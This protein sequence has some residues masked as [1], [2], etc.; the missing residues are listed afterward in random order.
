MKNLQNN[1]EQERNRAVMEIRK[2]CEHEKQRAIENTRRETK[3]TTWC[4]NCT[5]E[6][7]FYCCWNTSYCGQQCQKTHWQNHQKYCTNV[8]STERGCSISSE[9]FRS[10]KNSANEG[11]QPQQANKQTMNEA[12]VAIQPASN[13]TSVLRTPLQLQMQHPQVI[14]TGVSCFGQN[15]TSNDPQGS[16]VPAPPVSIQQHLILPP[17]GVT[18]MSPNMMPSQIF[19]SKQGPI[20]VYQNDT[21]RE[22]LPQNM[23]L[24]AIPRNSDGSA[25]NVI[26]NVALQEGQLHQ[27]LANVNNSMNN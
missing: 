26:S 13:R 15:L 10:Q 2:Q 18:L 25:I 20:R 24:Q 14:M 1:L 27:A 22:N 19:L 21:L 5:K 23:I 17:P 11:P 7:R 12:P 6:A 9:K 8:S 3:K 4:S 16:I